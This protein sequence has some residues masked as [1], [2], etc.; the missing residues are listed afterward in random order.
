MEVWFRCWLILKLQR[1]N[2]VTYNAFLER[3]SQRGN[4]DGFDPLWMPEFLFDFQKHLVEWSI[5]K[6][7]SAL[8][9]STFGYPPEIT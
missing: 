3:K 9:L 4:N 5:R 1:R 6:G 7:R 2:Y 8:L